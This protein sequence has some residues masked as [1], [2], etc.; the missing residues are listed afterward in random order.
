MKFYISS[1]EL[2]EKSLLKATRAH[3]SVENNLNWQFGISMNE[4][5]CRICQQ[6]STENLAT[7][8]HTSFNLLKNDKTFDGGIKRKHK[9]ENRNDSYRKLVVSGRAKSRNA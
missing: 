1:A 2:D 8:R 9:Q 5:S 4:D 3:W 7:V 6:N